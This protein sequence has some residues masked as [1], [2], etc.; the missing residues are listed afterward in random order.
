MELIIIRK[1][2]DLASLD[3]AFK[4][5][6]D[7]IDAPEVRSLAVLVSQGQRLGTSIVD[8]VRDYAD[9]LRLKWRQT[10]DEQASKAGAKLLFPVILCLLP[11]FF[12]ILWG[13]AVLELWKFLQGFDSQF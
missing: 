11:A 6:A 13:P 7:R 5:F 2:S 10:A 3:F 9:S 4:Q 12:I 8:S 1:Q